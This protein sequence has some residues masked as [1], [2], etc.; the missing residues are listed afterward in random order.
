MGW[1]GLEG[2]R[3]G[4]KRKG[5][6]EPWGHERSHGK[7]NPLFRVG[8][9]RGQERSHGEE[10]PTV[11]GRGAQGK[12]DGER[13]CAETEVRVG[14]MAGPREGPWRGQGL[15]GGWAQEGNVQSP[16]VGLGQRSP[17]SRPRPPPTPSQT[18]NWQGPSGLAM[19]THCCTHGKPE[20]PDGKET[21]QG[22]GPQLPKTQHLCAPPLPT[23]ARLPLFLVDP[24]RERCAGRGCPRA[25]VPASRCA[26]LRPSAPG[27]AGSCT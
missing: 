17:K 19:L 22:H 3:A 7:K 21:T 12:A 23:L 1:G 16:P 27:R 9:G 20:A 14:T 4:G 15:A 2:L 18:L 11:Q 6:Q 8:Q 26:S 25:A 5:G 10:E 24:T 13:G